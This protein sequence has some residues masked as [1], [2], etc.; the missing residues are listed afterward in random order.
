MQSRENR[1]ENLRFFR[2]TKS[3]VGHQSRFIFSEIKLKH[4]DFAEVLVDFNGAK[5]VL[6]ILSAGAMGWL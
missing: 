4:V 2:R 1:R 6:L 3:N 5:A